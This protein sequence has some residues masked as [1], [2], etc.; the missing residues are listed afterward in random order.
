MSSM[1][2]ERFL[3]VM[4]LVLI[5][6]LSSVAGSVID[7]QRARWKDNGYTGPFMQGEAYHSTLYTDH[8][9]NMYNGMV[10]VHGDLAID[11]YLFARGKVIQSEFEDMFTYDHAVVKGV[12]TSTWSDSANARSCSP[13]IDTQAGQLINCDVYIRANDNTAGGGPYAHSTS[14]GWIHF[15]APT[16]DSISDWGAVCSG[17]ETG[18][19]CGDG[20]IGIILTTASV[21]TQTC[22]LAWKGQYVYVVPEGDSTLTCDFT[23]VRQYYHPAATLLQ[24][25]MTGGVMGGFIS[26]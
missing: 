15:M 9:D 7:T 2:S 12:T 18:R 6:S 22:K 20:G 4:L 25:I 19:D 11:G 13:D 26:T 16:V 17:S 5:V 14:Y 8:I 21:G 23:V 1:N 3:W 24:S 10:F